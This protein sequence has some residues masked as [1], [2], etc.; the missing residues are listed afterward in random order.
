MAIQTKPPSLLQ[1]SLRLR[2]WFVVLSVAGA[3]VLPSYL[4]GALTVALPSIG[5]QIGLSPAEWSW[6]M[7]VLSLVNG[8][9]LL[10][11]GGLADSFGRRGMFLCGIAWMM[12][13]SIALAFIRQSTPFI[14]MSGVLGFGAALLAPAGTGI[15]GESLPD[16]KFKNGAF[17]ALGAGQPVGF[18]IGLLLG[19]V[20]GK[21]FFVLYV[22]NAV[23]AA[24]FGF[25]AW[26]CLPL[27]GE[28]IIIVQRGAQGREDLAIL[29]GRR[30]AN[31][32]DEI[33][34]A[35]PLKAF[36]W[37]GAIL[38][39]SG[40]V[41]FTLGIAFS[42]TEK[43]GWASVPVISMVPIG[44]SLMLS[45]FLWE[46]QVQR[47]TS[48][49]A[50]SANERQ[51]RIEPALR[52]PL[53]PPSIWS[54]PCFAS[55]LATIFFS[56]LSFNTL[57]YYCTLYFQEVQE[58]K[59]LA[60]SIRFLPMIGVG[61]VMNILGGYLVD[62]VSAFWLILSGLT[63][64]V[65]S[66][67]IFI[68]MD[69]NAGYEKGML[70]VMFLIVFTDIF[71]PAAQLFACYTVGPRR[72]AL[73][74]SLFNVT[75]RLATSIGLAA[76]TSI[77]T[78]VTDKYTREHSTTTPEAVK[79]ARLAGYRAA[80]WLCVAFTLLALLLVLITLRNVG[81]VGKIA[82][83][84]EPPM[85]DRSLSASS[86]R[87]ALHRTYTPPS[88]TPNGRGSPVGTPSLADSI[89]LQNLNEHG[90]TADELAVENII[91]PIAQI[92]KRELRADEAYLGGTITP[93]E[94]NAYRSGLA[95][96]KRSQ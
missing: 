73:A 81:V 1:P 41:M 56:W 11:S 58:L 71:Y 51:Q 40:M 28:R 44:A 45:F 36:D 21:Q 32:P 77:T 89:A 68:F 80:G 92:H 48:S 30:G 18:I 20:F 10:I 59:P 67:L 9:F 66:C 78:Y 50:G 24:V 13:F 47:Q 95:T 74:G 12:V 57:T 85:N 91:T 87:A 65:G 35:A 69:P 34:R 29:N 46:L 96:P 84:R 83:S 37:F 88:H 27:D 16:G 60:T 2:P 25:A 42:G 19:G 53:I 90:T 76:S 62:K 49:T 93:P 61:L 79:E 26:C 8:A 64:S 82:A 33:R 72:S 3:T 55:L 17:A 63:G 4:N 7:T 31:G 54:A 38:C 23:A 94:T 86:S 39:T 22:I 5:A 15:I 52:A 70:W 75:T 43:K 6:P 14:A